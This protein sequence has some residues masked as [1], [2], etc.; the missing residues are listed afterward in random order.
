VSFHST[1]RI[2]NQW[3]YSSFSDVGVTGVDLIVIEA[4]VHTTLCQL[5]SMIVED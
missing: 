3:N 1:L 2:K 4:F 5:L